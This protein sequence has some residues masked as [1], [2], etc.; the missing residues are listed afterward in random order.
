MPSLP[1]ILVDADAHSVVSLRRHTEDDLPRLLEQC[2]DPLSQAWTTVPLDYTP[3]QARQFITQAMPGGWESDEEWGFAVDV[4]GRFAGTVSLRNEGSQRAEIAYGAHPDVRGTGAMERALRLLLAWGFEEQGLQ[5]VVWWA[6]RGNWASRRL[7]WRLGFSYDGMLRQ[8]LPR[9]GERTDAWVGTLL[10]TDR[11]APSTLWLDVP[12]IESPRL[13]IRLR[14]ARETDL[15]RI[16]EGC[17]DAATQRWLGGLPSPY[18]DA[19]AADFVVRHGETAAAG[20][21]ATFV[22]ADRDDDRLLA[23]I[24][25]FTVST[26]TAS[27]EVGYWVHPDAR[28]RGV[29]TEA[30][31]LVLRHALLPTEVGGLGLARVTAHAAVAN[32]ASRGALAR[33][34]MTEVGVEHLGTRT[35]DGLADAVLF[36]VLSPASPEQS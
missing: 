9:R 14:A 6:N 8:W 31:R 15:P 34:G 20:T 17:Q 18:A 33:S 11:R 36:E 3:D 19:N 12:T 32:V 28:G 23:T 10:A 5:N 24:E 25:L 27:A 26:L 35:R 2:L 16:V 4:D 1:P 29:A 7:A 22:V 13:P 30:T 21:A